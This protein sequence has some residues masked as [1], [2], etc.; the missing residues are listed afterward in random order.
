MPWRYPVQHFLIYLLL[1]LFFSPAH[2]LTQFEFTRLEPTIKSKGSQ[3]FKQD[4][5]YSLAPGHLL[6]E[7]FT[8]YDKTSVAPA[9]SSYGQ[10]RLCFRSLRKKLYPI[11]PPNIII[12]DETKPVELSY[13]SELK[14]ERVEGWHASFVLNNQSLNGSTV[15]Q[16]DPGEWGFNPDCSVFTNG[17]EAAD[18]ALTAPSKVVITT[19]DDLLPEQF[20]QNH[21]FPYEQK[22]QNK[23]PEEVY[24]T[25]GSFSDD[26]DDKGDFFKRPGGFHLQPIIY[27]WSLKM[28]SLFYLPGVQPETREPAIRLI[29]WH[30]SWQNTEI[31]IP[32]ELWRV[33]LQR[34]HHRN[35]S[36]LAV[37]SQ[38]PNDTTKAYWQ[39][40][41][42]NP[43]LNHPYGVNPTLILDKLDLLA[44]IPG[45][46]P[47]PVGHP[48]EEREQMKRG[49]HNEGSQ[50]G[51]SGESA[52]KKL[53][54]F[55]GGHQREGEDDGH[56]PSKGSLCPLCGANVR[57]SSKIYC[58][59]CLAQQ[60]DTS[61]DGLNEKLKEA[62]EKGN[63]PLADKLI[64]QGASLDRGYILDTIKKYFDNNTI[65]GNKVVKL[66]LKAGSMKENDEVLLNLASSKVRDELRNE[67]N[68]L[69][70]GLLAT[71]SLI[72]D[73][74]STQISLQARTIIFGEA[75][76]QNNFE[77]AQMLSYMG[78]VYINSKQDILTKKLTEA[79]NN[80]DK[81]GALIL[82]ELGA[83][84]NDQ[85]LTFLA[86]NGLN[87]I[88]N[89]DKVKVFIRR[90]GKINIET[91]KSV[92][93]YCNE[94]FKSHMSALKTLLSNS[95]KDY[96]NDI[97][98]YAFEKNFF[99]AIGM[100]I[101]FP[102]KE[103]SDQ[104]RN[105]GLAYAA[106]SSRPDM[107]RK[108]IKD[109]AVPIDE[110]EDE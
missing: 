17:S 76:E 46:A 108:L 89:I 42:K 37:L 2:A 32:T 85:T 70:L 34:N 103:I 21:L 47:T 91:I 66:L 102:N 74:F 9:F 18:E 35:P 101:E 15:I 86:K 41:K 58:E 52:Q 27:E 43:D 13:A 82:F 25:G 36:V 81:K 93:E 19:A 88:K 64:D 38:H 84:L 45:K 73:L 39:W 75:L 16:Y 24:A 50:N 40:V 59:N 90:G 62:F 107:Y 22:N 20:S 78:G 106:N 68:N 5:Q 100:L 61:G 12:A 1:V 51:S 44:L 54:K 7:W 11:T 4:D 98:S 56:N 80:N 63:Y 26:S 31:A 23:Q 48:L 29:V 10:I 97:L 95:N 55:A 30:N 83:L 104:T 28:M 99:L 105:I 77:N 96:F 65:V 33:L 69:G 3:F 87:V 94:S 53:K 8:F 92:I 71:N 60:K 72:E 6:A 67:R 79:V 14:L 109:Y 110:D 49:S 57:D